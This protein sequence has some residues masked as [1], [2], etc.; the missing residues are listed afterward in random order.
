[1]DM[2]ITIGI[3]VGNMGDPTPDGTLVV[4]DLARAEDNEGTVQIPV[5]SPRCPCGGEMRWDD[6][7]Q[8]DA[9]GAAGAVCSCGHTCNTRHGVD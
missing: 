7:Y 2:H 8:I 5:V 6:G 1:M 9:E 3:Y 4:L